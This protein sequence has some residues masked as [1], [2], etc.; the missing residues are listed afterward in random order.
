M[1]AISY[2]G[3][4]LPGGRVSSVAAAGPGNG[5]G[6]GAADNAN[7]PFMRT[8]LEFFGAELAGALFATA[9]PVF[10]SFVP[11]LFCWANNGKAKNAIIAN[12]RH[13]LRI[14]FLPQRN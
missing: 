6:R 7:M 2:L 8:T 13:D 4:S 1:P 9:V 11:L 3:T 5:V 12:A 10:P 14:T